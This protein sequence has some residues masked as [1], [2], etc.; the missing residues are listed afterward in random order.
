M[1]RK[2]ID[3]IIQKSSNGELILYINNNMK[4]LDYIA[5]YSLENKYDT[6]LVLIFCKFLNLLHPKIKNKIFKYLIELDEFKE[7][8]PLILPNLNNLEKKY[9][10][11]YMGDMIY[12]NIIS[13]YSI[14]KNS[15][16]INSLFNYIKFY[17][18]EEIIKSA[19]YVVEN[20]EQLEIID[21]HCK[22]INIKSQ[23]IKELI[24]NKKMLFKL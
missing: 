10:I 5:T 16:K 12:I 2:T 17:I 21:N 4:Y 1:K 18:D 3:K 14:L 19:I 11:E 15:Y 23:E 7:I 13:L 24:K 8:I 9:L 20:V 22:Q 6:K